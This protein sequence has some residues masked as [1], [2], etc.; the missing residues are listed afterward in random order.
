[1]K[2]TEFIQTKEYKK[3]SE[4]CRACHRDQNI[5]L[6]FGQAGVGK[7]E[8]A[9][10]YTKWQKV[11]PLIGTRAPFPDVIPFPMQR[12]NSILYTPSILDQ[13]KSIITEI[14]YLS[15]QFSYLKEH[16]LY[17]PDIPSY[18]REKN[19]NFAELVII[20]EAERLKPQALEL[21]R[22]LYDT[23]DVNFIFIG[24]PGIERILERF[25]QLYSR[26]GFMHQ[27]QRLSKIEIEFIIEKHFSKLGVNIDAADF[28][29]QEA[30]SAVIRCTNGNF[31]LI[32]RLVKQAIRIMKVNNAVTLTSEI[33]E[34]A[35]SCLL[36]GEK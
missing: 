22:E 3:F 9:R 1:M 8:S 7:T 14:K 27:F 29:D 20:D 25:P 21:I 34:A 13:P 16:S 15:R 6:C 35:R 5:G 31:R 23:S 12:L 18:A 10:H 4:F 28:T 30:I 33:I 2:A 24:M 36:I 19:Q 26:I 11:F 17:G 32:N